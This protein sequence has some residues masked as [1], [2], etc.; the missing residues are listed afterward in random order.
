MAED[1]LIGSVID[2]RYE[3]R[4][5]LGHGGMGRLYRAWQASV[6][7][8]VAIKVIDR[9]LGA[10]PMAA[11]RFQREAELASRL[12]HPNTVSVFDFGRTA[13]GQLYIAMELIAG[14]TLTACIR[15][16][17]AFAL[18]RVARIGIQLC[19]ALE[20]AHA[21]GIVHRDLKLDNVMVLDEPAGR[22]LVK[23]LD[24]GLAKRKDDVGGTAM[25]IV[26]GTP[27]YIA[28]EVAVSGVASPASDMYAV[29]VM[30]AEMASGATLWAS[31]D[32][33]SLLAQ[34]L[35]PRE[36]IEVPPA[37]RVVTRALLD[38]RP[39]RR[40]SA[41]QVRAMLVRVEQG[42]AADVHVEEAA[43]LEAP[44]REE[45]AVRRSRPRRRWL[46]LAAAGGA[47]VAGTVAFVAT[48]AS[49]EKRLGPAA[50]RARGSSAGNGSAENEHAEQGTSS[51]EH[52]AQGSAADDAAPVVDPWAE[53]PVDAGRARRK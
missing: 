21:L 29:G 49:D 53:V 47:L 32:L 20:A 12:S 25:G 17:G 43:P 42:D 6:R 27:R 1:P 7:R 15:D 18:A 31:N 48:R 14:K 41:A 22:D 50:A 26:V 37:L 2:G 28:P 39:E 11:T 16:Q 23:I 34:K 10:D 30:L 24:F 35:Q 5:A 52:A 4:G 13:S 46:V 33:S 36:V 45:R 9:S 8:E 38:P 3:V 19:D 44:T 51:I 40:P